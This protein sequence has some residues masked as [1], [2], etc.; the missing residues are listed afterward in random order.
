MG[1]CSVDGCE[2]KH[3]GNGWCQLHNR[4]AREHNGDP[5]AARR[6]GTAVCGVDGCAN[7]HHA[8]GL[9]VAHEHRARRHGDPF[10]GG[11]QR[12][13]GPVIDRILARC[14]VNESTGCWDWTGGLDGNGYGQVSVGSGIRRATHRVMFEHFVS[15]IPDGLHLDHMCERPTCC[16]PYHLDPVTRE[17]NVRRAREGRN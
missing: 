12:D 4:R 2:R 7:K 14:V 3:Y 15:D 6:Y 5:L 1:G 10:A 17:E 8:H 16:N 11:Q 9:C 13:H